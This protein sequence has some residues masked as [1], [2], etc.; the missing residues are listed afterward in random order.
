MGIYLGLGS[1]L[2]DRVK[3][4]QRALENF[5]ILQQ[6]SFYESEPVDFLEQPWF[7]NA[8]VNID[9]NLS[10]NDLLAFCLDIENKMGRVRNRPKGPRVIDIDILF[11]EDIIL[12]TPSLILPHPQVA[13]RRFVLEPLNEIASSFV[14]PVLNETISDLLIHCKDLSTVRKL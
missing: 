7:V 10:P 5:S 4:L 14:H 9:I 11:Y 8:A 3:N 1:N 13:Y 6:S 2:G 12:S